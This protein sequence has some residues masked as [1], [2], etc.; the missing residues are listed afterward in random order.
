MEFLLNPVDSVMVKNLY[1]D[2][3]GRYMI[4]GS[5]DPTDKKF[6]RSHWKEHDEKRRVVEE[7]CFCSTRLVFSTVPSLLGIGSCNGD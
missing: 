6:K 1:R 5:F 2:F 7:P 4:L 3:G